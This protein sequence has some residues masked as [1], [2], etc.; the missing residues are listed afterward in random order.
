MIIPINSSPTTAGNLIRRH[1]GGV[2]TRITIANANFAK[3]G[4]APA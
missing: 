3:L 1:N 2:P 4:R